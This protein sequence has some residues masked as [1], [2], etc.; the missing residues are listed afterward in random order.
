M[1]FRR[2][3]KTDHAR[4]LAWQAWLGANAA[5]LW[6]AGL[7]PSVL[8]TP[9]DWRVPAPPRVSLCRAVPEHRLPAGGA[10][11][12]AAG[13]VPGPAGGDARRGGPGVWGLALRLSSPPDGP[14]I[15]R[16]HAWRRA[17]MARSH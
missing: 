1:T 4:T 17:A 6:A 12:G 14:G 16:S 7:P 5:L 2:D 11:G 9:D 13:G 15:A 8:R 10:E 3:G